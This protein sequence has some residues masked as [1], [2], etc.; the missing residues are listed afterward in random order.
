MRIP[1]AGSPARTA[2]TTSA[3]GPASTS[4]SLRQAARSSA[5]RAW[6]S[7]GPRAARPQR[8]QRGGGVAVQHDVGVGVLAQL[9]GVDVEAHEGAPGDRALPQVGVAQLAADDQHRV[10]LRGGR[11]QRSQPDGRAHRQR[12]GLVE[13]GL[14]VDG[15]GHR[16]AER[17]GHG[18]QRA[19]GVDGAA[20][21]DDQRVGAPRPAGR[22]PGAGRRGAAGGAGGCRGRR[23]RAG[24][25]LP[26]RRGGSRCARGAGPPAR[27]RRTPRRRR[28]P[29]PRASTRRL[30][31]TIRSSA[32][33][34]SLVSCS[35]PRSG[36]VPVGAPGD[37]SSTGRDSAQEVA[38]AAAALIRP[39][40]EVVTT[41][42]GAPTTHAD[43]VGRVPG[44]LL[45]ARGH[46]PDAGRGEAA[47]ELQVVRARDA[48]HGLDAVRGQGLDHRGAAVAWSEPRRQHGQQLVG[49]VRGRDAGDLGVVVGRGDLDDVGADH[50][51]ARPARAG[52]AAARGW[53]ARPP[54]GCRCRG[55]GP[56]RARRCRPRR[57]PG[58]SPRR[59]RIRS[60]TA[61]SPS[62]W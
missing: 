34:A 37:S 24:P 13:H 26:A 18:P 61:A 31:A 40:P 56:G 58:A 9:G 1:S 44:A 30:H 59:A 20:P 28:R 54:R 45:V 25:G 3:N 23:C 7:A 55:R 33:V 22:P 16:R 12:V 21:R 52:S 62:S 48:E 47:V 29:P 41:T 42:P 2:A 15:G 6:P 49:D 8:R 39:G 14:A 4:A 19:R 17:L 53:S 60:T 11:L 5:A 46:R 38:A 51:R 57:R 43:G 27:T 36:P 10:A 32:P 50:V 35:L